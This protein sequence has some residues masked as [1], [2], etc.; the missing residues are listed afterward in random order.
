MITGNEPA[1]PLSICVD[2]NGI[3][4]SSQTEMGNEANGL[5]IR[6]KFAESFMAALL[7]NTNGIIGDIPAL[8]NIALCAVRA[9]DAL[10]NELNK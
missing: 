7:S 1:N 3:Y 8:E 2:E 4:N 10:I 6:Q 5:T 9:A